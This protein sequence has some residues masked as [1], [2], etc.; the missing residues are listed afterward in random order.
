VIRATIVIENERARLG[1]Y[2][3]AERAL[4]AGRV[5]VQVKGLHGRRRA[6]TT[7]PLAADAE[8]VAIEA[9]LVMRGGLTQVVAYY[10]VL[11][12]DLDATEVHAEDGEETHRYAVKLRVA[13]RRGA[14]VPQV[15]A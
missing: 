13:C 8:L 12:R 10:S 5:V 4:P 11:E 1:F 7:I 6:F 2:S 9:P 15:S 14:P 3:M